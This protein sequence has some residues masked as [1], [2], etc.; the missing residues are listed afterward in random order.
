MDLILTWR[1]LR[2]VYRLKVESSEEQ[3]PNPPAHKP[4]V[5]GRVVVSRFLR[6]QP[7]RIGLGH[8]L[9]RD[10]ARTIDKLPAHTS[11]QES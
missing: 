8:P 5:C 7:R 3:K 6:S 11:G 4:I 10:P 1:W 2:G 9:G